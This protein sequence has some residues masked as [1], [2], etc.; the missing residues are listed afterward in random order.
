MNR[1]WVLLQTKLQTAPV[2]VSV[3]NGLAVIR[4]GLLVRRSSIAAWF[5]RLSARFAGCLIFA[6]HCLDAVVAAVLSRVR[7]PSTVRLS[8]DPHPP[9]AEGPG[10][11]FRPEAE[12]PPPPRATFPQK[13][14][15]LLSCVGRKR[16]TA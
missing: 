11:P 6:S 14:F 10:G 4:D 12:G 13:F 2:G 3:I 5:A 16:P 15:A 7:R 8:S 9:I 1:F